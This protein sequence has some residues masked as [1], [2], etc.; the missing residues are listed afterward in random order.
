MEKKE[1]IFI[2]C[3]VLSLIVGYII[4]AWNDRYKK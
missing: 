2:L 4:G 1:I 3:F